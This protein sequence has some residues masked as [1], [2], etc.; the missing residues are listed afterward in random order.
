MRT[1]F[2]LIIPICFA[3]IFLGVGSFVFLGQ[4]DQA[5][6]EAIKQGRHFLNHLRAGNYERATKDFGGNTCRC[7][8]EMGWVSYLIYASG[9]EPN[10]AFLF[11][12]NFEQGQPQ[13]KKMSTKAVAKTVLDQPEDYE[14]AIPIT[15][16]DIEKAPCFLPLDLAYGYN[17]S[18]NQ[19]NEFVDN[20]DKEAWKGLTLRLRTSLKADSTVIAPEAQKLITRNKKRIAQLKAT[21]LEQQ[22]QDSTALVRDALG[23]NSESNRYLTPKAP[24]QVLKAD[25][26]AMSLDE[27]EAKLPRLKSAV[28]RLHLVRH[29]QI[30][31]FTVFHFVVS[32]PVLE[33]GN[34][35]KSVVLKSFKPPLENNQ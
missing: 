22:T 18:E 26:S 13:V 32:D 17:L 29:D 7:P 12:Q 35:R 15:F 14:V 31:P 5:S 11:G 1:N 16:S 21:G 25:N 19:L 27:L 28:I 20:P 33:A 4:S 6:S 30:H 2:F 23:E 9:E 34:P 3:F 10:L 24:G 8:A